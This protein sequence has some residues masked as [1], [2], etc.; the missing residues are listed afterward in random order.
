M[1]QV[2]SDLAV[3]SGGGPIVTKAVVN[4]SDRLNIS[5]RDLAKIL[6]V[7]PATASRM[8]NGQHVVKADTKPYE[9]SVL[10]IRLYR[11]L[12][13]II[14]GDDKVAAS[15][16]NNENTALGGKPAMLIQNVEGLSD[17]VRYLDCRRAPV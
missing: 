2:R 6:G 8:R 4:A 10:L 13:A 12:D 9:L 11:S 1:A 14:G 3:R 15:W 7:S 17:V 16:L 5:A